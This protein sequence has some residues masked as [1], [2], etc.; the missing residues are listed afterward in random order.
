MCS[1]GGCAILVITWTTTNRR[2]RCRRRTCNHTFRP[3]L[4]ALPN[5]HVAPTG[6]TGP[7]QDVH[8]HLVL[9]SQFAGNVQ[10]LSTRAV[11]RL[12]QWT[13]IRQSTSNDEDWMQSIKAST[14]DCPLDNSHHSHSL[15]FVPVPSGVRP[16][17]ERRQDGESPAFIWI[18]GCQTDTGVGRIMLLIRSGPNSS[19]AYARNPRSVWHFYSPGVATCIT[20][21]ACVRFWG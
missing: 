5:H 11:Q 9:R 15:P 7:K 2:Q 13:D 17:V 8:Q 20:R 21:R 3:I 18:L 14:T 10:R 1:V 19:G 16:L 6:Q 12:E 4:Y